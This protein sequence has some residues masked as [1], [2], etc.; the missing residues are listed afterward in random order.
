MSA[1]TFH[2]QRH[3]TATPFLAAMQAQLEANEARNGL[4]LGLALLVERDPNHYGDDPYLATLHPVAERAAAPV[5]AALMTPPHG[6]VLYCEA[7]E[8]ALIDA[9]L[10]P[11]IENLHVEGWA[12]PTVHGPAAAAARFADHWSALTGEPH[13]LAVALRAFELRRVNHPRYSRGDLRPATRADQAL[14]VQWFCAFEEE[15]LAAEAAAERRTHLEKSVAQKIADGHLFFWVDG[16]PVS[17]AGLTRP[18]AHGI[19]I[20]PV[21]TPPEQRGRGYATAAVAR[22]SQQMLDAGKEFCALFTDLANPT[23]NHIYQQIGYRALG[24]F[25]QYRFGA[26]EAERGENE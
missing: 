18:T 8:P 1:T 3:A 15:A 9:A 24:D 26:A 16:Q 13:T 12:V 11:L 5:V 4:M 10:Q 23:S 17:M 21:Y 6:I 2:C 7:T 22:L 14:A 19:S 20:G 25:V